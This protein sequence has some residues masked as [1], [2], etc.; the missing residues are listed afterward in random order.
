VLSLLA[1]LALSPVQFKYRWFYVA[2]NFFVPESV[3][4]TVAL[5][6]RA[7]KAGYNGMVFTDSKIESRDPYPDFYVRNVQ[8]MLQAADAEHIQVYPAVLGVGYADALLANDPSLVE[9]MPCRHVAFMAHKGQLV[10][11]PNPATTYVNGGFES[12]HGDK[13]DGFSYQDGPGQTSFADRDVHHGG[14]QSLR[15]ENPGGL[16]DTN[17]NCRIVQ[18]VTVDPWRQ[19]RL[20]V[21][22]KTQDFDAAGSVHAEALRQNGQSLSFTDIAIKPTQDWTKEQIVFNSQEETQALIYIGVWGGGKGKMWLDD[23]KLE[24]AG[25]LNVTRRPGCP[26]KITDSSG[27]RRSEKS[28]VEPIVDPKFGNVPWEGEFDIEHDAPIVQLAPGSRISEGQTVYLDYYAAASTDVG[29]TAICMSEPK[30]VALMQR[31]VNKVQDLFHPKGFFLAHDEIRV[32]NWC[33]ACQKRGL[34]PGQI[35][36]ENVRQASKFVQ[37]ASS[38]AN[39]FFWSDMFDPFHNSVKSYYL[40]NGSVEDSWKGLPPNAVIVNWNSGRP[41]ESLAFFAA[42]GFRQILAGYYDG[43]VDSI[44]DWLKVAGTVN[45]VQGVMYTTWIGRYDDLESFAKAAWGG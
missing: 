14:T 19:Y 24:D 21:W 26:L 23:V 12:A 16:K 35:L 32:M 25:L 9:S 7:A 37:A 10:Q 13:F 28:D 2:S 15:M 6:H 40:C 45:G 42:H 33:D 44:K 39:T 31:E 34:T 1:A 11:V 20:T 29:K 27:E 8:R 17:G 36:A 3:D 30:T 43:P 22:V 41:K 18:K 38:G 4:Q 5:I